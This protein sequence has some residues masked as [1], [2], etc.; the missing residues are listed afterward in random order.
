MCGI[1]GVVRWDD[2]HP[3]PAAVRAMCDAMVHRGPDEEGQ[4]VDA[5]VALGMRRLSIIDLATGQQPVANEDESVWVVF[6]GEIYNFRELRADLVSRGHRFATTTDTEVIVH[7]YEEYG[8]DAVHHLR[9]MFAFAVWDANTKTLFLAR[10]RVGIKPLFYAPLRGSLAFASE[11]KCLLELPEISRSLNWAA[12]ANVVTLLSTPATDSI[13]DGVK[14][15]DAGHRM[16]VTASGEVKIDRYWDLRFEPETGRRDE[17]V[18]A[19]L[20]EALDEAVRL[21]LRSDVPLG[22]FLSGG[23]DSSAIV[24]LMTRLNTGRVK[25]FSIGFDEPAF[26]ERAYA[27]QTAERLGTE[28]HEMVVRP[29]SLDVVEKIVWHLDEPFGDSSAIPTYF[30]SELAGQH[31][32]VVLTGDGGDELFGGYDKYLVEAKERRLDRVPHWIRRPLGMVGR[33]MPFGMTGRRF[34]NHLAEDGA[35]RYLDASTLFA[36]RDHSSLFHPDL[37][38]QMRVIDPLADARAALMSA[39]KGTT[40]PALQYCDVRSYLPLDILV[41]VDRMTM[42]H[43]VEARPPLVDHKV[44]ELAARMPVAAHVRGTK[45]KYLFKQAVAPLLPPEV[46]TRPKQGFAV[47]LGSWFRGP[48]TSFAHDI[49]L[50]KRSVER[51]IFNPRYVQR[52]LEVNQ[53]GRNLDR[54]LWTLVSFEQWC[55]LF[56]DGQPSVAVDSV[57]RLVARPA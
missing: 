10:D 28:H 34:L 45:A 41:K 5:R 44:L 6:N 27:R 52:L 16:V 26:D 19:E 56:L 14:K 53:R 32:K 1:A 40:L 36:P 38:Q 17:D 39:G 23:V 48:W 37:A 7:L 3:S 24:S 50:S 11:L 46:V 18:V 54:E 15:L 8:I 13:V 2:A 31:V 21:H 12:A 55:R 43:S 42:A 51:G 49:L 25:T 9:G 57:P 29:Q 20:R 30:V 35:N 4:Y 47:P 22:A 33:A